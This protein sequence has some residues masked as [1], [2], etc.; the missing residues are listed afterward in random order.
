MYICM[1]VWSNIIAVTEL[2][3]IINYCIV[4]YPTYVHKW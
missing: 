3:M 4:K 2:I 1:H